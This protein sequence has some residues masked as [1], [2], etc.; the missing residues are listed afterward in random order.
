MLQK[1]LDEFTIGQ[2]DKIAEI[3]KDFND[4]K[5]LLKGIEE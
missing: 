1:N 3:N 4:F 5:L 2:K